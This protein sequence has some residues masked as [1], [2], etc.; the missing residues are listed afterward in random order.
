MKVIINRCWGGFSL[1]KKALKMISEKG[2]GTS[3]DETSANSFRF[4]P[5]V[6]EVVEQLGDEANGDYAKLRIV[7]IPFES[8]EGW[9]I[10]DY[11]G[12]E[13][14]REEHRSW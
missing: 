5:T 12:M 9:Y 8:D 11:D 14:I 6:V 13:T 3:Y 10:D 4:N 2:V 7:E 1:S